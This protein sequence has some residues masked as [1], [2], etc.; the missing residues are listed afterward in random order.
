M[1]RA[2]KIERFRYDLNLARNPE[3]PC[4]AVTSASSFLS[5]FAANLYGPYFNPQQQQQ[6]QQHLM[7]QQQYHQYQQHPQQFVS[8]ILHLKEQGVRSC[9]VLLLLLA[10]PCS[11]VLCF[12][13]AG[14][15]P[16][17]WLRQRGQRGQ[18]LHV[19]SA[20]LCALSAKN[21]Q[22]FV[23]FFF[24]IL[25]LLTFSFPFRS[26]DQRVHL[27]QMQPMAFAGGRQGGGSGS[28]KPNKVR[29]PQ[30][31]FLSHHFSR[32]PDMCR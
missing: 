6:Q 30:L 2:N 12:F 18:E 23:S 20:L 7:A 13:P 24:L 17:A 26:S 1:L 28:K 25:L 9:L 19:S 29:T 31:S 14:Y 15:S 3:I 27:K 11:A 16:F 8:A 4:P 5:I 32:I 21:G 22:M 10:L